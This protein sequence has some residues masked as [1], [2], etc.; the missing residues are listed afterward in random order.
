MNFNKDKENPIPAIDSQTE[1]DEM[2]SKRYLARG[3]VNLINRLDTKLYWERKFGKETLKALKENS[4]VK[5]SEEYEEKLEKLD[6]V[7]PGE[8]LSLIM[9]PELKDVRKYVLVHKLSPYF[10]DEGA[11]WRFLEKVDGMTDKEIATMVKKFKDANLCTDTSKALW[12]VLHEEGLFKT[13]YP[14]WNR[15]I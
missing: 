4:G 12:K 1:P 9:V 3:S 5:L 15:L 8:D 10:K 11:I 7:R 2:I 13:D 6:D 14:N